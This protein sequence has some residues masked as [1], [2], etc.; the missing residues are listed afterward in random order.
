MRSIAY[1]LLR[2][3]RM[4]TGVGHGD[5]A[6]NG[7]GACS[8]GSRANFRRAIWAT[9]SMRILLMSGQQVALIYVELRLC[10]FDVADQSNSRVCVVLHDAR[11]FG[12]FVIVHPLSEGGTARS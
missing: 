3:C 10:V 8:S 6:G 7:G 12:L 1:L 9:S 2:T 5:H 4:Q 11:G